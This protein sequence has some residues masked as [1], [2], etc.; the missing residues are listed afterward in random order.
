[1]TDAT[2]DIQEVSFKFVFFLPVAGGV[3]CDAAT[4]TVRLQRLSR[5]NR[6]FARQS[7]IQR[8]FDA[9]FTF[10]PRFQP[11]AIKISLVVC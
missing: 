6:P 2:V 11:I 3:R 10:D 7:V 9:V 5:G 8:K 4:P 1:M